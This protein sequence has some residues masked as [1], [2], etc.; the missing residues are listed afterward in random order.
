MS[1]LKHW[2]LNSKAFHPPKNQYIKPQNPYR[3]AVFNV[4]N[5]VEGA[6]LCRVSPE[7]HGFRYGTTFPQEHPKTERNFNTGKPARPHE[8]C[9]VSVKKAGVKNAKHEDRVQLQ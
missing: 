6:V 8:E 7:S 5:A 2:L 1:R 4:G 9:P 3:K